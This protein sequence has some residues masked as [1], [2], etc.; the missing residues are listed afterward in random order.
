MLSRFVIISMF[1]LSLFVLGI[2]C[3]VFFLCCCL[4]VSNSAI[5]CL[6]RLVSEMTNES[7]KMRN[8]AHLSM[9]QLIVMF[10]IQLYCSHKLEN[11]FLLKSDT[12]AIFIVL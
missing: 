11:L 4:V 6:E 7:D 10:T 3:L 5:E 1:Q 2:L 8:A 9:H 12:E